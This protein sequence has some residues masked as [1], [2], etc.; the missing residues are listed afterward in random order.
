M[1]RV[2]LT[3]GFILAV[4]AI[5][6]STAAQVA[7]SRFGISIDGVELASFSTFAGLGSTSDQVEVTQT[8]PGGQAVVR[9]IPGKLRYRDVTV[10]RPFSSDTALAAWREAIELG[11]LT[12]GRKTVDL[13]GYNAAGTPVLRYHLENAWPSAIEVYVDRATGVPMESV[14]LV[15]ETIQRLPP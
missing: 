7:A 12:A 8:T 2:A 11:D 4:S 9:K 3:L 10:Q 15:A 5:A 1:Q 6:S 14:T 13:I